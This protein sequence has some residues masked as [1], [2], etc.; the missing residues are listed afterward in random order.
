MRIFIG[1]LTALFGL[2]CVGGSVWAFMFAASS[3]TPQP[4]LLGAVFALLAAGLGVFIY[5]DFQ[6]FFGKK[7]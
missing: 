7:N 1:I 2:G 3:G 4:I 5:H 6:Y